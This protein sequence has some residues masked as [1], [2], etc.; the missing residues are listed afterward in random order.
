MRNRVVNILM[1]IFNFMCFSIVGSFTKQMVKL[2]IDQLKPEFER[3]AERAADRAME[4]KSNKVKEMQD[5]L[6]KRERD[7]R[8]M[9]LEKKILQVCHI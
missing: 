7:L 5:E 1:V 4:S 2:A 6:N 8:Q 3:M 9:K